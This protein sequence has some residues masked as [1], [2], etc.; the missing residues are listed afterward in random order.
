MKTINGKLINE[1]TKNAKQIK[2]RI[3][4]IFQNV[5]NLEPVLGEHNQQ[6]KSTISALKY[7]EER[8]NS[9]ENN[10][11]DSLQ[12]RLE[13]LEGKISQKLLTITTISVMGL[14]SLWGC[15]FWQNNHLFSSPEESPQSTQLINQYFS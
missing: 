8:L 9:I 15:F 13:K 11:L 12:I 6:I 10:R 4:D 14:G 3:E 1:E 2:I 7:L 5:K